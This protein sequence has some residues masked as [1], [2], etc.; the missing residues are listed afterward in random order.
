M[1]AILGNAKDLLF[2]DACK[3]ALKIYGTNF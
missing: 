1:L 3:Q 2:H